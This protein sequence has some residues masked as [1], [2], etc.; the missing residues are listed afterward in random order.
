[1]KS[2]IISAVAFAAISLSACNGNNNQAKENAGTVD[3]SWSQLSTANTNSAIKSNNSISGIVSGYLNLK[4]SV[5]EDNSSDAAS[6]IC[7]W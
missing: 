5:A 4:N 6:S 1:M 3:T 7:H 2:L